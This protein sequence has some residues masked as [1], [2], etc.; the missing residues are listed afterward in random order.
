MTGKEEVILS[1]C[2]PTYNRPQ[3]FERLMKSVVP[4]LSSETEV[5]IRDD[6]PNDNTKELVEKYLTPS[7]VKYRYFHGG[8]IG[9]DAA[10]LFVF[11]NATGKYVWWFSDDEE[12][13]PGAISHVLAVVKKF[14]DITFMWANF[15]FTGTNTLALPGLEEGFFKDRN[16]VIDKVKNDLTLMTTL[17]FKRE[18]AMPSLDLA[19]KHVW[20]F[21]LAMLTPIFY[22][23]SKNGRF[24]FLK[25]PYVICHPSTTLDIITAQ[26]SDDKER[27]DKAE[28]I[29]DNYFQV[30]GINLFDIFGD[31]QEAFD[32]KAARRYLSMAFGNSWRTVFMG[33]VNGYGSPR[34]KIV[35][36]IK[37]YW[38]FPECWIATVLFIMPRW[39]DGG[40]YRVYRAIRRIT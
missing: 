40:I 26:I 3:E 16:D 13:A 10:N 35:P 22:L 5:V 9:L 12:M 38:N 30:F 27:R 32:K 34:R 7:G 25:G 24:Y 17:I 31:F 15:V 20:G 1:I 2:V 37:L 8:K 6:S 36:M 11:E 29:I 21:G 19:K 4:Q 18:E 23:L 39:V 14:P 33:W 28:K